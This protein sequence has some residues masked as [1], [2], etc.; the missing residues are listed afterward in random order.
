MPLCSAISLTLPLATTCTEKGGTRLDLFFLGPYL[1]HMEVPSLGVESELQLAA[2]T[3]ATATWDPSRLCNLYH[4]PWQRQIRNPM[5]EARDR[6]PILM[7]TSLVC[8]H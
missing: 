2:Y 5:S 7:D 6:T 4:S 8:Y 3:T 1:W